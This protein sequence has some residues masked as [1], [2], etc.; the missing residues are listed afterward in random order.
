MV[1]ATTHGPGWRIRFSDA[2][3]LAVKLSALVLMVVDHLDWFLFDSALGLHGTVG[4]AVFPLFALTLARN[5][6]RAESRH[7]L[8]VVAPRMLAIGVLASLPYAYLAGWYP[9][10]VMFT[11]AAAVAIHATWHMGY[12]HVAFWAFLLAG[13]VVDYQWFGLGCVLLSAWAMQRQAWPVVVH[14][15]AMAVMLWPVNLGWW[16]LVAVPLFALCATLEGPAPRLK[17][18]FYAVYPAHLVA[19]V[20]LANA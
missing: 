18:L 20:V 13:F 3:W 1:T 7:M 4:R 10:N 17:W 2:A 6:A 14:L 8:R 15:S 19:L 16:A 9:L 12:R 11:L 5:L